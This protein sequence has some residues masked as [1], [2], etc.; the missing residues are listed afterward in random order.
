MN[1]FL[2]KTLFRE[3]GMKRLLML[4][5]FA[6]PMFAQ[7]KV[8]SVYPPSHVNSTDFF[9]TVDDTTGGVPL[10]DSLCKSRSF[11][12]N[13]TD[14]LQSLY[15]IGVKTVYFNLAIQDTGTVFIDYALSEDGYNWAAF[16]VK[17]S[18]SYQGT[19]FGQKS[20][21]FTSTVL[22]KAFVRF[23]LRASA[24]AFALGDATK[25]WASYTL[26]VY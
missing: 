8:V 16:A 21:D 4:L 9:F 17:D 19:S 2:G 10:A 23:R 11:N 12:V 14:T 15:V 3:Y 7:N 6:V 1:D 20:V 5:V 26:K 22:G 18:L 13:L 24:L 25:L